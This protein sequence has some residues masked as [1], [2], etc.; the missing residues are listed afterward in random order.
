MV[1]LVLWGC[2]VRTQR[3]VLEILDW[4]KAI[5]CGSH[6]MTSLKLSSLKSEATH[7]LFVCLS[8]TRFFHTVI[9]ILSFPLIYASASQAVFKPSGA[10]W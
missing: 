2:W 4:L 8:L 9:L 3:V 7:C 5:Y 10:V 6:H 1:V